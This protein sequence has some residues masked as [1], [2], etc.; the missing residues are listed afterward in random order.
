ME[1][2]WDVHTLLR[3]LDGI[4]NTLYISLVAIF[5][6]IIG[7][8]LFG[9]LMN[10]PFLL[11]RFLCRLYLE[12]IRIIP[13]IAWLFIVYFGFSSLFSLSALQASIIVFSLWG[14]AEFGD[15]VRGAITSIPPHQT[16]SARALGLSALQIQ[17]F[18]ILPQTLLQLLPS[19]LNLATRMIKT[20]ALV[21]LIGVMD[22][23]KIGQQIIELKSL[24]FPQVSFFIYGEIFF[25]YFVLCYFLS[26]FGD[27]LEKK[28]RF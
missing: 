14:I 13:I 25:I 9:I 6:S 5:F 27:R 22:L 26:F 16:Q 10:S 15:L 17:F 3:I 28:L 21:S 19:S 11:L 1:V 12:S 7:G 23:L 18:V 20:T 8:F 24:E 4:K 2:L